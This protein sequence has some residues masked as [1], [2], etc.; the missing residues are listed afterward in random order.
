MITP[1]DGSYL[2]KG[3]DTADTSWMAAR[4]AEL[5]KVY[6]LEGIQSVLQLE[7]NLQRWPRQSERDEIKAVP[8]GDSLF[9][10]C[11]GFVHVQNFLVPDSRL[12]PEE[13][14]PG[15]Y[16]P[17][18]SHGFEEMKSLLV[19]DRAH[20]IRFSSHGWPG[21]MTDLQV[22]SAEDVCISHMHV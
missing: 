8:T 15:F 22:L 6:T 10:G 4:V 20:Q 2:V 14:S 19:F 18:L 16:R 3:A 11:V 5:V 12:L 9:E 1:P 13:D 17:D 7:A 21:N